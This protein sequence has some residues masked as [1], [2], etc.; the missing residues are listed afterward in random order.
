VGGPEEVAA[1][2]LEFADLGISQFL[3]LGDSDLGD[4]TAFHREVLPLVRAKQA[5]AGWP[6]EADTGNGRSLTNSPRM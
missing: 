3:F 2:I 1:A 4:M 6:S 5:S